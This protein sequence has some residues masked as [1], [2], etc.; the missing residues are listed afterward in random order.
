MCA[1]E[2]VLRRV[3]RLLG[4]VIP[5]SRDAWVVRIDL[6]GSH[7][8][9]FLQF[10]CTLRLIVGRDLTLPHPFSHI[11]P[12]WFTDAPAPSNSS[13]FSTM[14]DWL[15]ARLRG[16]G[17]SSRRGMLSNG[18]VGD[19]EKAQ[20]P[21]PPPPHSSKEDADATTPGTSVDSPLPPTPRR[22]R[23]DD[24]HHSFAESVHSVL[25]TLVSSRAGGSGDFNSY[26]DRPLSPFPPNTTSA[27]CQAQEVAVAPPGVL[28]PHPVRLPGA[29]PRRL[30]DLRLW[31]AVPPGQVERR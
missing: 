1:L 8:R 23:R 29:A 11:V 18:E 28:Y 6:N 15:L 13:P 16:A 22:L 4:F 7:S 24:S 21:A 10:T 12:Q 17:G 5:K 2:H 3:D 9:L 27:P 26:I 14:R 31:L 19:E 30:P 20:L 25:T